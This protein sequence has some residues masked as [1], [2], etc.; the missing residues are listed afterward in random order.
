MCFAFVFVS[1]FG[2]AFRLSFFIPSESSLALLGCLVSQ[3]SSESESGVFSMSSSF[4][5]DE[6]MAWSHSWP[7]TAWHCFLKGTQS[8][9]GM[10]CPEPGHD[11]MWMLKTYQCDQKNDLLGKKKYWYNTSVHFTAHYCCTLKTQARITSTCES[12]LTP[13]VQDQYCTSIHVSLFFFF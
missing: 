13:F 11:F 7:S 4:S 3:A 10:S 1:F 5:D 8:Q 12:I 2:S 6:D 9:A